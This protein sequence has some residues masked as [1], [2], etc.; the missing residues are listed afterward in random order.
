MTDMRVPVLR[1]WPSRLVAATLVLVVLATATDSAR[2]QTSEEFVVR[3]AARM[4]PDG[5]L[6]F[7][8]QR[9]D[10]EGT[11]R[12]LH[13][14]YE[15]FFPRDVTHNHWLEGSATHLLQAPYYDARGR[16]RTAPVGTR[17]A[18]ARVIAR[19][20]PADGRVEFALQHK[21]GAVQ[22][23][24]ALDDYSAPV[25]ATRRFFPDDVTHNR[26]LYSSE[27]RFTRVWA[28]DESMEAEPTLEEEAP[29][30]VRPAPAPVT[31]EKCLAYIA[32]G[33]MPSEHCA[34]VMPAYAEEHPEVCDEFPDWCRRRE[35]GG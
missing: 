12:L 10:D 11:P 20:H 1:L 31:V 33:A 19:V 23:N 4:Q 27:I 30:A 13:L 26:W 28:G 24:A 14:E 29:D 17:A 21:L 32:M 5:R 6:E 15:R 35:G 18:E 25:F 2:A 34:D 16:D 9:I 8:I 22:L 3:I 7:G